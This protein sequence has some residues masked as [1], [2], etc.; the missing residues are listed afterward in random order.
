VPTGAQVSRINASACSGPNY[1]GQPDLLNSLG[2]PILD[3]HE[4]WGFTYKPSTMG[5]RRPWRHSP[6]FPFIRER[7]QAPIVR[8]WVRFK[9]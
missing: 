5:N 4:P 3:H 6:G 2:R 8:P 9:T 7:V 1:S